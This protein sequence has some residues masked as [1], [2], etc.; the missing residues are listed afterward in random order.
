MDDLSVLGR[1]EE[2]RRFHRRAGGRL[3]TRTGE[4]GA[5]AVEFALVMTLLLGLVFGVIQYGMY[6]FAMQTG[7]SA[8]NQAV[9]RLSVGDCQDLNAELKPFL[10]SKLRTAMEG[11]QDAIIPV[12]TWTKADGTTVG[13]ETGGSVQL[14]MSFPAMDL[15]FPFI[16]VPNNGTVTRRVDAR[17]EDTS[18]VAGGCS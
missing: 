9:R 17:V 18:P 8:A 4:R 12:V 3:F 5:A 1:N 15:H 11:N 10:Y 14:T 6:F 13:Q 2:M 16:P 7:T